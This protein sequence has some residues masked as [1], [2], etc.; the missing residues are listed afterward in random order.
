MSFNVLVVV[1]YVVNLVVFVLFIEGL[2]EGIAWL[3]A[4]AILFIV[5]L[6][7]AALVYRDCMR[8]TN[9]KGKSLGWA[10]ASVYVWQVVIPTYIL[11]RR[12]KSL[13]TT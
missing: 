13:K 10:L 12:R 6:L 8:M 9:S 3:V 5:P 11:W 1:L 4:Y 2:F 7:N